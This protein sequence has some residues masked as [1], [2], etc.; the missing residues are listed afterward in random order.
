MLPKTD[1]SLPPSRYLLMLEA[2]AIYEL[3]VFYAM[4]PLLRL[5]PAGDGHPVLVLPGFGASDISTAPLRMFL[6]GLGY[7]AHGWRLGM[8]LGPRADVDEK[9]HKRLEWL[10]E[11]YGCKVSLIGWSLGGVFA[12]EMARQ[13]PELVRCVIT[14]GSP[15]AGEPR[16]NHGWRLYETLS[17]RKADDWPDRERMKQPPPMPSTAIYSRS[18]GVVAWQGC[19]EQVSPS[20]ENIEVESSH[21]GFG[22]HPAVLYAIADRLSQPEGHWKPFNRE[23]GLRRAIYR[24][25]SQQESVG[26]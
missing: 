9:M 14:M 17:G 10:H 7:R 18:D 16:A 26:T 25:A 13:S 4:A 5:A 24:E 12:R 3:G 21:C 2:R 22:H 23:T 11:H 15:F 20:S 1:P 6:R 19:L 8:N